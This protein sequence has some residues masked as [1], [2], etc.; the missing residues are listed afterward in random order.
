[1]SLAF[2][3]LLWVKP[4]YQELLFVKR[5]F[6]LLIFF[7]YPIQSVL[8]SRPFVSSHD[9]EIFR[10]KYTRFYLVQEASLIFPTVFRN[11]N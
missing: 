1:M 3:L 7:I 11:K 6:L 9:V 5:K 8:S 2:K 4:S 10:W